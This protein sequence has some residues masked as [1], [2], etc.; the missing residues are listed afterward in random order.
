MH[1][2]TVSVD[3]STAWDADASLAQELPPKLKASS[4]V[5]SRFIVR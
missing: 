4:K 3:C 2:Y 1:T 5:S